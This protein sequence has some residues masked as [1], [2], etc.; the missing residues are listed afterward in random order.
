MRTEHKWGLVVILIVIAVVI[1]FVVSYAGGSGAKAPETLDFVNRNGNANGAERV[2]DSNGPR[3]R[4]EPAA[5]PPVR[6]PPRTSPNVPPGTAGFGASPAP[7]GDRPLSTDQPLIPGTRGTAPGAPPT[8]TPSQT[9]PTA[10]LPPVAVPRTAAVDPS[11]SDEMSTAKPSAESPAAAPGRLVDAGVPASPTAPASTPDVGPEV[12]PPP[13][14]TSPPAPPPSATPTAPLTRLVESGTSATT[15]DTYVVKEGDNLSYIAEEYYGDQKHW[16]VIRD[17]NPG[18]DPA[19]LF[20][21]KTLILPPKA[22]VLAGNWK[23]GAAGVK[24]GDAKPAAVPG[25]T[26][27]RAGRA[28]Y[29]VA[30]GDSLRKIARAVLKD[31]NRWRELYELNRDKLKSPDVVPVGTELRLPEA[32]GG[33]SA[34]D[35]G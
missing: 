27:P 16:V 21:G 10:N 2:A 22:A 33:K 8:A 18:V 12:V 31:E 24:P 25:N 34:G 15:G 11:P 4:P 13:A 9:T 28:T 14:R 1:W 30:A 29:K 17:A 7:T 19:R 6:T 20:V 3:R 35:R 5:T 23:S 32:T 26:A